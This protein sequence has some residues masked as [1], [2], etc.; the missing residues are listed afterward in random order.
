MLLHGKTPLPAGAAASSPPMAI[1]D[2]VAH[3]E[4]HV[5]ILGAQLAAGEHWRSTMEGGSPTRAHAPSAAGLSPHA[6]GRSTPVAGLGD[7]SA[8]QL[9]AR[10][11]GIPTAPGGR[12][13]IEATFSLLETADAQ[14]Y[15]CYHSGALLQ[16]WSPG[17]GRKKLPPP[18]PPPA[19]I[20]AG[21]TADGRSEAADEDDDV[22]IPPPI[23]SVAHQ[24]WAQGEV[25]PKPL[26]F[27]PT[28]VA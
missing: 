4:S 23:A 10:S 8:A 3:H 17:S 18:P 21:A 22:A 13:K 7:A 9:R 14:C 6:S 12:P 24:L 5:A 11:G 20:P 26:I 16:S 27:P 2:D 25:P 28:R 19:M 1:K 15:H